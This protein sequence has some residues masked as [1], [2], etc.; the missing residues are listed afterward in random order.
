MTHDHT[1]TFDDAPGRLSHDELLALPQLFLVM[2]CDRPKA[3]GARYCLSGVNTVEIGRAAERFGSVENGVLRVGVPGKSMSGR[4]ASLVRAEAGWLLKDEGSTNGSFVNG[5]AAKQALLA[6]G[7]VLEL[8]HSIFVVR[9]RLPTPPFAPAIQ[10]SLA[11][12][13]LDPALAT[14]LPG[15]SRELT[16]L[17]R[18]AS[19]DLS[20]LLFGETGTGKEMTARAVHSLSG[21][22]GAFVAVNCGALSPQ[23]TESL[24][25]GHVKGA[26]SGAHRDE[27][28]FVRMADHGTLLLDE[29]GDLPLGAQAALLRVLQ[30]REVVPVGSPRPVPV[31]ARVIA[32]T[33]RPLSALVESD[34]FRRDLFA[35]LD[36]YRCTLPA[37][38]DR[39]E[40]LGVLMAEVLRSL[41]DGDR[42][43]LTPEAGTAL[44]AYHWPFNI[45]ELGQ[46][47][48]RATVLTEDG[49]IRKE[50]LLLQDDEEAELESKDSPRSA[51]RPLSAEDAKLRE[52]LV[53]KL[54]E[55]H[56]NLADVARSM[57]KARMQIH[58]WLNR[59][60]I[61]PGV[62]R[63][64]SRK[65]ER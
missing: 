47:L 29:V 17:A 51:A 40:D 50:H 26:F 11:T 49:V 8:G 65:P 57:G 59:L 55:Y 61:D 44:L 64:K 25:F 22:A 27:I 5:V 38:A 6:E 37:L 2:E 18:V 20:L 9:E 56:G 33:H 53:L 23:L 21:R 41:P 36:G 10:D 45:R 62:F 3:G 34:R 46:H 1:E 39:L 19:S 30:E 28:G 42:L 58:R 48:K 14:L 24:L 43:R 12:P 52:E 4:H 31:N 35:R 16:T 13:A 63:L 54:S 7:D 15:L 32:A 60:D